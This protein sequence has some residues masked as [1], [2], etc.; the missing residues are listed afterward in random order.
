MDIK[1]LE[2]QIEADGHK[3]QS[4][5]NLTV[6]VMTLGEVN[7]QLKLINEIENR[8]HINLLTV[9]KKNKVYQIVQDWS[10]NILID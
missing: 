5:L 2:Q 8:L 6:G 9:E 7:E 4:L 1:D 10:G 3:L